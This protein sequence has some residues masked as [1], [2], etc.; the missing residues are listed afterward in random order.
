[1][2][3]SVLGFVT[4]F[5]ELGASG[6]LQCL[7]GWRGSQTLEPDCEHRRWIHVYHGSIVIQFGTILVR[8]TRLA[9]STGVCFLNRYCQV[10]VGDTYRLDGRMCGHFMDGITNHINNTFSPHDQILCIQWFMQALMRADSA[11]IVTGG[12]G[13]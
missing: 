3:Y 11:H 8:R 9:L 1:M 7:C 2:N 5:I 4:A 12:G 10:C 6:Y 13:S